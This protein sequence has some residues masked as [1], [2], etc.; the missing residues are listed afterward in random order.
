MHYD[1]IAGAAGSAS[2]AEN[3]DKRQFPPGDEE[4]KRQA[5]AL[6]AQLKQVGFRFVVGFVVQ[7]R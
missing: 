2:A 3:F 1:A 5:L 7:C 4:S 6:A